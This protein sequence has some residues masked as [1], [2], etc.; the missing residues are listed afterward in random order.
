VSADDFM[1]IIVNAIK[2]GYTI[3][4]CGDV[5]EA[6][7]DKEKQV[8]MIPS[9]DIPSEYINDDA[10]QLR[11]ENG[12]TTDD[13]CIHLVG[14]LMKDNKYW[15]LAKDSGAGAF[16]GKYPGYKYLSED[17]VKLKMMNILLYKY[18]AKEVLDKIIK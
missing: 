18:A 10:R 14:Y 8:A 13:H 17:Y 16:D 7:I 15:F 3:S 2:S 12:S 11:L 1:K 6:G 5:S 9:F 4:I